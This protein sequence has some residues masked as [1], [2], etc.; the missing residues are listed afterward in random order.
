MAN[1]NIRRLHPGDETVLEAFLIPR[2]ETSMF[3]IGNMRTSGLAYN[4]E[5]YTGDYVA[6]FEE[7]EIV[8]A[9]AHFWNGIMIVQAPVHLDALWHAA[10]AASGRPLKGV[11]GPH[12]QVAA[13]KATLK[14]DRYERQLDQREELYSL[15]LTALRVPEALVTGRVKGR[16]AETHDT[17]ALTRWRVGYDVETLGDKETDELWTQERAMAERV[18]A[19]GNTWVLEAEGRPVATSAFNSRIREAVQIGGVWTP[20]EFRSRGYARCVVAQSLLD[21]HKEGAQKAILFTGED[22]IAAQKA[23]TAL[24]FRHIGDY[25]LLMLREPLDV[26]V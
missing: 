1:V 18:V 7:G 17:D 11:L 9:A 21:A 16:R 6:A 25:H 15:D 5:R 14:L 19:E 2:L 20:P 13:V 8:G 24:G 22:N 23:Y 4:G 26:T 12:D 10:L 3:L